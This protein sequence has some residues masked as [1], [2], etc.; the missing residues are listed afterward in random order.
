MSKSI[1][2]TKKQT[3][4]ME[5]VE[6][7]DADKLF[8]IIN[9]FKDFKTQMRWR[10]KFDTFSPVQLISKYLHRSRHG[11]NIVNYKQN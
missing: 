7:F 9:N 3:K 5:L 4:Y 2:E 6:T 1:N 8:Y 10:K 11:S